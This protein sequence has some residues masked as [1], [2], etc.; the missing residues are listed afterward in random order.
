MQK[1]RRQEGFRLCQCRRGNT[2]DLHDRVQKFSVPC[3]RFLPDGVAV[4]AEIV[5]QQRPAALALENQTTVRVFYPGS[6]LQNGDH[7]I[8]THSGADHAV[9]VPGKSGQTVRQKKGHS[10]GNSVFFGISPGGGQGCRVNVG[11]DYG[12][13]FPGQK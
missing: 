13:R 10:G 9:K 6:A 5:P 11:C 1:R 3:Q 2:E 7:G 4:P 8:G 12:I